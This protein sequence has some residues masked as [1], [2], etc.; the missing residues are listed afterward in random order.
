MRAPLPKRAESASATWPAGT[1]GTAL[2]A[3]ACGVVS[4]HSDCGASTPPE[5]NG[6]PR[7]AGAI[8]PVVGVAENNEFCPAACAD[9]ACGTSKGRMIASAGHSRPRAAN[10]GALLMARPFSAQIA[11]FLS[12]QAGFAPREPLC[13]AKKSPPPCHLQKPRRSVKPMELTGPGPSK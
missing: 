4:G 3:V 6:S 10:A 1:I 11:E 12:P 2:G 8:R 13:W 5:P 7:V 9:A